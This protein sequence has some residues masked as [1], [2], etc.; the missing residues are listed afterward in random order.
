LIVG[1]ESGGGRGASTRTTG[2]SIA[3]SSHNN[4]SNNNI[5]T[6]INNIN[7]NTDNCRQWHICIGIFVDSCRYGID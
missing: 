6:N 2:R 1:C 5:G 7:N 4:N 3:C